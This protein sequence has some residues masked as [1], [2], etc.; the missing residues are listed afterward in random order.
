[1]RAYA[2]SKSTRF[3]TS[4][5][6][7]SFVQKCAAVVAERCCLWFGCRPG[8]YLGDYQCAQNKDGLASLGT[9]QPSPCPAHFFNYRHP[10]ADVQ[11]SVAC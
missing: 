4:S 5:C 8:L 6:E 2:F 1:M 9:R 3:R 11:A 10:V 7:A